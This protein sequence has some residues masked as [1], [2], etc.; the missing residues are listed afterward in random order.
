[1]ARPLQEVCHARGGRYEQG[2][3]FGRQGSRGVRPAGHVARPL[4][5][6]SGRGGALVHGLREARVQPADCRQAALG[7]GAQVQQADPRR[8]EVS[9]RCRRPGALRCQARQLAAKVGRPLR[10]ALRFRHRALVGGHA[11]N[12]RV[13]APLLPC[14][15]G[16]LGRDQREENRH[17][18]GWL[19][20]LRARRRPDSVP[21]MQHSQRGGREDHAAMRADP[22][23]GA[24]KRQ[25]NPGVLQQ[26]RLPPRGRRARRC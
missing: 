3:G 19:H 23:C 4:R 1:M 15:R 8:V 13:A 21:V 5:L 18:V 25:A 16:L 6:P 10:E 24:G 22:G 26:Q 12:R 20:H 14:A 11:G 2:Q 9:A 7:Q 17:V